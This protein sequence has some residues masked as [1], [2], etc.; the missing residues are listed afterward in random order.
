[1]D[2]LR[3]TPARSALVS[4]HVPTYRTQRTGVGNRYGRGTSGSGGRNTHVRCTCGWTCN[5]NQPKSEATK[6]FKDHLRGVLTMG[7]F[8]VERE[9]YEGYVTSSVYGYGTP[10][11]QDILRSMPLGASHEVQVPSYSGGGLIRY[12]RVAWPVS[13]ADVVE[14][15]AW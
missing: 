13:P 10:D 8:V 7:L 12:T 15:D 9:R 1:M 5:A 6:S 3:L 4:E 2:S 14:I 11:D